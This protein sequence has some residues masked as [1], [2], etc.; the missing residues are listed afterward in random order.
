LP[1]AVFELP[2]VLDLNAAATL[3]TH[4]IEHRGE[5]LRIDAG[6]VDRL[7]GLCLQVLLSARRA[8]TEDGRNLEVHPRSP[9]FTE[10][11]TLF[12]ASPRFIVGGAHG[13]TSCS[14]F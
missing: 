13:E 4:L 3:K 1:A 12:G 8:W 9:A 10:T 2:R 11:L 6:G 14:T 7:G 5:D